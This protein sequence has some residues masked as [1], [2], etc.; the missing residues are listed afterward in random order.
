M[1]V[2][3]LPIEITFE[4]DIYIAKCPLIQG[5]FAEWKTSNE[6]LKELIDVINIINE[7][8]KWQNSNLDKYKLNTKKY[9]TTLPLEVYG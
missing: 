5:A 8:K 1:K 6:A 3:N 7:Y 4:E 9:S 2:F